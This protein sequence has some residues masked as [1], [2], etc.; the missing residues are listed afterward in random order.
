MDWLHEQECGKIFVI[1][2]AGLFWFEAIPCTDR[3]TKGVVT[4]LRTIV[5]RFGKPYTVVSGNRKEVV[6]E[7]FKDWMTTQGCCKSDTPLYSPRKN[8]LAKRAIQTME[9]S[10]KF[11]N[12]NIGYFLGT[13]I[14][15]VM[16]THRN[17]SNA[18]GYTPE[19]LL[20][21]R[22]LGT[23][24]SDSMMFSETHV[25]VDCQP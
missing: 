22:G 23:Q 11:F 19:K 7:Y 15:K 25:E 2:D 18:R 14:D 24:S 12:K 20:L 6:S 16:F 9:H 5:F 4:C 8:G 17:S 1:A 21:G 3:A 10:L 13:Y